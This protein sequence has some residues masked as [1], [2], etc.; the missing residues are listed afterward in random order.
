MPKL[1]VLVLSFPEFTVIST[2]SDGPLWTS[3]HQETM[4]D[5]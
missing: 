4:K 3:T 1:R 2:K 5:E